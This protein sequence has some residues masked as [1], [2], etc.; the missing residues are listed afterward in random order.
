[1]GPEAEHRIHFFI[2]LFFNIFRDSLF[3]CSKI[4][5]TTRKK[6]KKY[7]KYVLVKVIIQFT[8]TW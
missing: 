4:V 1:M 8:L 2:Y 7:G 3:V 5:T 6:E